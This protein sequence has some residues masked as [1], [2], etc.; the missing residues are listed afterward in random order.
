MSDRRPIDLDGSDAFFEYVIDLRRIASFDPNNVSRDENANS[1]FST[2]ATSSDSNGESTLGS[3]DDS[4]QP[5]YG[6]ALEALD[7]NA[8]LWLEYGAPILTLPDDL[9]PDDVTTMTRRGALAA[10]AA[11]IATAAGVGTVGAQEANDGSALNF[12]VDVTPNPRAAAGL[13]IAEA[14]V[15][16][17]ALE[18]VDDNGDE[19]SLS[20]VGGRIEER[21]TEGDPHNPISFSANELTAPE[22]EAFPRGETYDESGDGDAETDVSALDATHWSTTAAEASVSNYTPASGGKGI[23]F[24]T[25][26]VAS[27]SEAG[28]RFEDVETSSG[29]LRKW[30]QVGMTVV[31]NAGTMEFRVEDATGSTTTVVV[32]GSSPDWD[33][34]T[35]E[36]SVFQVQLG[37]VA[38]S[39]DTIA[40]LEVVAVDGDAEAD[41]FALNLDRESAWTFGEREVTNSDDELETEQ[42]EEPTGSISITSTETIGEEFSDGMIDGLSVDAEITAGGGPASDIEYELTEPGNPAY[43][44]RLTMIASIEIPTAFALSYE[45]LSLEVENRLPDQYST[46]EVGDGYADPQGLDDYSDLSLSDVTTDVD[47]VEEGSAATVM[48]DPSVGNYAVVYIEADVTQGQLEEIESGAV[49]GWLGGSGG[50]GGGMWSF[51][52]GPRAIIGGA[53]V[54]AVGYISSKAGLISSLL[55]R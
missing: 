18:Y 12:D 13:S 35:G 10:G 25:S 46:V 6:A 16:G 23:N 7:R 38:S 26:G 49:V 36:P 45:S 30:L 24:S 33:P 9:I 17:S 15:E 28:I 1:D 48:S 41:I 40:A 5:D 42:I 4:E 14:G 31:S 22:F 21:P 51:L 19:V 43:D 11:G 32:G 20:A 54:G 2:M 44:Q 39:I 53:V 3:N 27:G 34:A 47:G 55:G 50:S 8:I 37:D 52:S 29:E